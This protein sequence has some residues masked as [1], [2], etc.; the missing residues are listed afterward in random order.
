MGEHV[1]LIKYPYNLWPLGQ[2]AP[3]GYQTWQKI[4]AILF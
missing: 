3:G 2:D 4:Q 1:R